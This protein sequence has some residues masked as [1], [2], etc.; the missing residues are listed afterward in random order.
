[1][2]NAKVL[3]IFFVFDFYFLEFKESSCLLKNIYK[4]K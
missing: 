2:N 3:F 1:M 4:K